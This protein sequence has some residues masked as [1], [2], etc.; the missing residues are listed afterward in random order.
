[1][2][3]SKSSKYF[4]LFLAFILAIGLFGPASAPTVASAANLHPALAQLA[5]ESPE[6]A[7]AVIVQKAETSDRA[8]K[9]VARLGGTVTKDLHIINAF[10]AEMTAGAASRLAADTA[11]RWVSL[12]A[13][14][15]RSGKGRTGGSGTAT[16]NYFLET[17]GVRQVWNMGLHGEGISVAVIDSGISNDADF[18]GNTSTNYDAMAAKIPIDGNGGRTLR[19]MSFNP[20]STTVNDVYGHGTHVAGIIG[21]NGS[22]SS[23]VYSGIAPLVNL[24]S[25]KI[26][27]EAGMAYESDTVAAIQW[28]LDNKATYN[29]RVVN[30]SINSTVEQSYH[31]SPLDAAAEILWFNGV[32]VVASAGNKGPGGG[33]NTANAAPANDPFIIT[34]G[35]SDEKGSTGR[36]D[37][38]VAPFSAEG[39]TSDGFSKPDIIAPGTNIYSVLS[40]SS[41]WG[42]LYP[43]RLAYNGEY[44]RLSGTSMAAPMVAGAVALLLQDEPNLTPDQVKHRLMSTGIL[45]DSGL[46]QKS[47]LNIYAAVTGSTTQSANTGIAV[48]QLLWTGSEPVN[49]NSVNWNSVNW[50][51]VNWNAVNWNAVNWNAVNWNSVNWGP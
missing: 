51:A 3:K 50:N 45:I 24:I 49:W 17:L 9:L 43:N 2:N 32:V 4:Q 34:V 48:S 21:G 31:T 29:I 38:T 6:Q 13:P 42:T 44:F 26:S 37:D 28:V 33:Y 1:M 5:V 36:T 40:K 15:E 46:G 25:L 8:E 22:D 30:L 11:V 14:V 18:S 39:R 12:D 41:A 10:A 35:A 16:Q 7:V 27:D 19:Q 47:Y 20:N 23:G